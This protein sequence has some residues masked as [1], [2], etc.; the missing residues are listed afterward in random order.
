MLQ[1]QMVSLT[2][3]LV[4]EGTWRPLFNRNILDMSINTLRNGKCC[5]H[6]GVVAEAFSYLDEA[7]R[8][9]LAILFSR[10]LDGQCTAP[11]SWKRIPLMCIFKDDKE[12]KSDSMRGIAICPQTYKL[13]M[14]ILL[15]K[16]GSHFDWN[17]LVQ[18]GSKKW[19]QASEMILCVRIVVEKC[20]E[21]H[22]P[23]VLCK[24]DIRG[25]FDNVHPEAAMDMMIS[26]ELPVELQLGFLQE[27]VSEWEDVW[28]KPCVAGCEGD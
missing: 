10:R 12:A 19:M 3:C 24:A 25:A 14:R 18:F 15:N 7:S 8:E 26:R 23:L 11:K 5:D 17:Y 6:E 21:W 27:L 16:S 4:R 2:M 1:L 20:E 28:C 22:I 9:Q 13:Y